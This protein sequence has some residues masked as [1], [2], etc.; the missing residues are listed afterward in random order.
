MSDSRRHPT[1][2]S[3]CDPAA[4]QENQTGESIRHG[5]KPTLQGV[6]R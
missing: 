3:R 2:H 1:S 6:A 4:N 5:Y